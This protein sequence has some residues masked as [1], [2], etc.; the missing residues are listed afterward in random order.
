MFNTAK[1]TIKKA[2]KDQVEFVGAILTGVFVGSIFTLAYVKFWKEGDVTFADIGGML[3][4][5]GTVGLLFVA[6]KTA[7]SWREQ[8][9]ESDKRESL[10]K[11]YETSL[12]V[13]NSLIQL[14]VALKGAKESSIKSPGTELEAIKHRHLETT[15]LE[16]IKTRHTQYL[17]AARLLVHWNGLE[18]K[19]ATPVDFIKYADQIELLF[20][21][22]SPEEGLRKAI[23]VVLD[24]EKVLLHAY[25]KYGNTLVDNPRYKQN[26]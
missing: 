22:H 4:G 15:R 13:Q 8:L 1:N 14:I 12:Q 9:H 3:A 7:R 17:A 24:L 5:T 11:F 16:Q 25:S 2:A 10:N 23:T 20:T 21:E 18:I 19:G 26:N 6:I